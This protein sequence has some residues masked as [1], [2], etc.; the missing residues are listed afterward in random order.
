MVPEL[1]IK[2]AVLITTYNGNKWVEQQLLSILNQSK[3]HQASM[4]PTQS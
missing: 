4:M 1:N 2:I 3:V